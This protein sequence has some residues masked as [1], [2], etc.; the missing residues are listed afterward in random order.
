M[1]TLIDID[2]LFTVRHYTLLAYKNVL[3][4]SVHQNQQQSAY[5]LER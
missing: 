1:L 3:H 5:S 4:I 2:M